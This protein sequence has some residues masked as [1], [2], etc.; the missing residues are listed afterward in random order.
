[1]NLCQYIES[2]RVKEPD[3]IVDRLLSLSSRRLWHVHQL[4]SNASMYNCSKT[5]HSLELATRLKTVRS[6]KPN[7][8]AGSVG[9]N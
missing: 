1:M 8:E 9:V 3:L 4:A 2:I 6:S 7:A 5:A